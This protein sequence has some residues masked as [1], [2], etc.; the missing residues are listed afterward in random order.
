MKK[1]DEMEKSILVRSQALGYRAVVLALCVWTFFNCYQ[2]LINGNDYEPLPGLLVC[3]A[4]CVQSF[5]QL[6]VKRKMVAGDE[7]Y[8]EPNKLVQ[9][10][11]VAIIIAAVVL[12]VGTF[13]VL[14]V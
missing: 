10:I 4:V 11:A 9:A 2:T 5:S 13:V 3:F 14:K 6:A 7:E 8:K 12:S 1:M